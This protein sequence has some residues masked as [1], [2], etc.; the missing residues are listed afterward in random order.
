[1]LQGATK[2]CRVLV[3]SRYAVRHTVRRQAEDL[4]LLPQPRPGSAYTTVVSSS[5]VL[6]TST[7][8]DRVGQT[9]H[10]HV[11][12]LPYVAVGIYIV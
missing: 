8:E 12:H 1:M 6:N 2:S 7:N 3:Q 4:A 5:E 10:L 9:R 11:L